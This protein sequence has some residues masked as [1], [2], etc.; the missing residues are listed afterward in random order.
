MQCTNKEGKKNRFI[1]SG[2]NFFGAEAGATDK[3][4]DAA[5]DVAFAGRPLLIFAGLELVL[6]MQSIK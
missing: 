5:M 1:V 2:N 3:T 6:P 4:T